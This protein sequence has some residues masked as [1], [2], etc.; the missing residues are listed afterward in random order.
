MTNNLYSSALP[1]TLVATLLAP[2]FPATASFDQQHLPSSIVKNS[3]FS[4]S[5]IDSNIPMP[6]E[7]RIVAVSD[8][9]FTKKL[10]TFFEDLASKQHRLPYEAAKLLEE[11][12]IDLC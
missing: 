12:L 8:E 5:L 2:S 1:I 7:H 9:E 4:Y 3:E 6:C 10:I 11:N